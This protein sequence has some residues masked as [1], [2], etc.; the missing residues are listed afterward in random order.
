MYQMRTVVSKYDKKYGKRNTYNFS[1]FPEIL[2]SYQY[3]SK[4]KYQINS[5]LQRKSTN[6]FLTAGKMDVA[7]NSIMLN[8]TATT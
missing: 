3:L 5:H 2:K 4:L 6:R 8:K 7:R 1:Y